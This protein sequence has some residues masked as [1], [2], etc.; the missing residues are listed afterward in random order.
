[1]TN[2]T[3][4]VQRTRAVMALTAITAPLEIF[5]DAAVP[6]TAFDKQLRKVARWRDECA[7]LT[8]GTR[9]ASGAQRD[10]DATC[11]SLTPYL[12]TESM[13]HNAR[14]RRWAELAWVGAILATDVMHTCPEYGKDRSWVYLDMT[15]W[16][17][18]RM[19]MQMAPRLRRGRHGHLHGPVWL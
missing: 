2:R 5:T 15:A 1:M 12:Q 19:L 6:G 14:L 7:K 3:A 8:R 10:I 11:A 16:T 17:L 13:D 18:G 9:L 4:S